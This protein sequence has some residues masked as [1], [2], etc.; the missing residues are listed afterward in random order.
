MNLFKAM[1]DMLD[2]AKNL[3]SQTV[4]S[5]IIEELKNNQDISEWVEAGI[6]L[7]DDHK[8]DNCLFCNQSLPKDRILELS[9]HFSVAD[10]ELKQNLDDLILGFSRL[11]QIIGLIEYPDK[12]R[13]YS[14]FE[15]SYEKSYIKFNEERSLLL[16][17]II[18][19]EAAIKDKKSKTTESIPFKE[20]IDVKPFDEA[21]NNLDNFIDKH[22]EKTLDFDKEKE[23]ATN[24]LK[25]HYL[26][27][28]F[29]DVKNL[30]G[31]I[32]NCKD[33]VE[34]LNAG[35]KAILND[36]GIADLKKR[37]SE[38]QA[39]ISSTH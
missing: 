7:H 20:T 39:K 35:N 18:K 6:R 36:L 34:K 33:E 2:S 37:I 9:K 27:T 26:S 13:F 23:E 38:N 24:K 14:E 21:V 19:I 12:A 11:Y 5:Q 25:N 30:E 1:E 10:K 32:S 22:N 17:K 28:I 4:E 8:A 16:E 3:L 29:D 31:D 15:G